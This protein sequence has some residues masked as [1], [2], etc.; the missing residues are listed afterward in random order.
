MT[1]DQD[2]IMTKVM[3]LKL[4]TLIMRNGVELLRECYRKTILQ[5]NTLAKSLCSRLFLEF[6]SKLII[7]AIAFPTTCCW[8]NQ[9]VSDH[10]QNHIQF[11]RFEENLSNLN[12]K[13]MLTDSPIKGI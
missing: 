10:F 9:L 8:L 3:W 4:G 11:N 13:N 6:K 1:L 12:Y 5:E 2:F 7:N